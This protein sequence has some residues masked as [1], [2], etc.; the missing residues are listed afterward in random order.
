MKILLDIK[1]DKADAV[2]EVLNGL[3]DVKIIPLTHQKKMNILLGIKEAVEQ[4]MLI[5]S[6]N[7]D[8]IPARSLLNEL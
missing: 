5:K 4:V 7:L 2:L 8:G 6:G 3:K 1:D